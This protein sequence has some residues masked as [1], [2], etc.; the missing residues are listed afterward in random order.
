MP[1]LLKHVNNLIIQFNKSLQKKQPQATTNQGNNKDI[2]DELTR[3]AE[4][5]QKLI[6]VF[7]QKPTKNEKVI[8]EYAQRASKIHHKIT[9]LTSKKSTD[10]NDIKDSLNKLQD[11]IQSSLEKLHVPLSH[12]SQGILT[13]K[14]MKTAPAHLSKENSFR[15][16][17]H[18]APH[19]QSQHRTFLGMKGKGK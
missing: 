10:I 16:H 1:D 9:Q 13:Q 12:S 2:K 11:A 4:Q 17:Q 19:V 14:G 5:A 8:S 3:N 7:I 6:T 15:A 18:V